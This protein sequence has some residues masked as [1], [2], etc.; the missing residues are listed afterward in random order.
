MGKIKDSLNNNRNVMLISFIS[1]ALFISIIFYFLPVRYEY[2]DDFGIVRTLTEASGFKPC[3]HNLFLSQILNYALYFLYK[4]RPV[5][6]WYGIFVYLALC[7]GTSLILSVLFKSGRKKAA[8]FALPALF[9]FIGHCIILASFTSACLILEFA[10]FLCLMEWAI[11]KKCPFKNQ[12]LYGLLLAGCLLLSFL[13]RWRLVL[14]TTCFALPI[15]CWTRWRQ[16]KAALPVIGILVVFVC[17]DRGLFYFTSP[18]DMMSFVDYNK[19]RSQFCDYAGGAYRSD[20]TVNAIAKAGWAPGDYACFA[21]WL[22]LYD[23]ILFNSRSLRLFLEENNSN[24]VLPSLTAIIMKTGSAL[25]RSCYYTVILISSILI[26]LFYRLNHILDFSVNCQTRIAISFCIIAG[27]I[28]CL[29]NSRFLERV[30]IPLY[31]YLFSAFFLMTHI[32]NGDVQTHKIPIFGKKIILQLCV[33]SLCLTAGA[34]YLQCE[35][36]LHLLSNSE[37]RKKHISSSLD[38]VERYSRMKNPHPIPL[39]V[40][41]D[42]NDNLGTRYVNPLKEFSDFTMLRLFPS[43]WQ[44]N[45]GHYYDA[46]KKMGIDGGRDFLKWIINRDEVFLSLLGRGHKYNR[47]I[48]GLWLSYYARNITQEQNLEFAPIFDFSN[49]DGFGLIFYNLR[50][51]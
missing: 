39:I 32:K 19:L 11:A 26:C 24:N 13:L 31:L 10:V 30:F 3:P 48:Q 35:R 45:S 1:S 6:P 34:A 38:Q 23:E 14:F 2:N 17:F 44:I 49:K 18:D 25:S 5:F 12:K 8:L 41:M 36:C 16:I 27:G 40:P 21:N 28:V 9:I 51:K 46:L 22:M 47:Y 20:V 15:L 29:M 4:W 7:L 42:P 37:I 50:S 33:V 43:G